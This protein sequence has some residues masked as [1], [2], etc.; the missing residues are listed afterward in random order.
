MRISSDLT[1]VLLLGYRVA[2]LRVNVCV[3]YHFILRGL[4]YRGA[5][6]HPTHM[7]DLDKEKP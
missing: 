5:A 3:P 2:R 6:W 1:Q 7:S 4:D